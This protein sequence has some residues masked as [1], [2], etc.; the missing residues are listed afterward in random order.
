LVLKEIQYK[1]LQE[2]K[3]KIW[4]AWADANGDLVPHNGAAGIV[5]K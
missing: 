2:E 1:Y 3:V 5:K 4:D